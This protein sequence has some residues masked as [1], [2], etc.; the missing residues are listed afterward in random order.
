MKKCFMAIYNEKKKEISKFDIF[1]N[2]R[3]HVLTLFHSMQYQQELKSKILVWTPIAKLFYRKTVSTNLHAGLTMNLLCI[4]AGA[5]SNS[6]LV[7]NACDYLI[8]FFIVYV[9]VLN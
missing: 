3:D 8:M 6:S 1:T 4:S 5:S 7:K 9:L 2:P